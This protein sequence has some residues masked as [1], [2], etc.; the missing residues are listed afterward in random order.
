[1]AIAV[2]VSRAA[3]AASLSEAVNFAETG[4]INPGNRPI[5]GV[6]WKSF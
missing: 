4:T 2:V 1:M 5:G 3:L 6:F